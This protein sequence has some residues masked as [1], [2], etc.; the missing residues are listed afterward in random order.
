MNFQMRY[1]HGKGLASYVY[2]EAEEGDA[3]ARACQKANEDLAKNRQGTYPGAIYNPPKTVYVVEYSQLWNRPVR[4]GIK[5]K[6]VYCYAKF[7]NSQKQV[8][9]FKEWYEIMD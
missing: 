1:N 9:A 5:F 4:G 3:K 6:L 7:T 8:T 2:F